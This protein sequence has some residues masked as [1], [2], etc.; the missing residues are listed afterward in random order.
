MQTIYKIM[1]H[2]FS[3]AREKL[4][5]TISVCL[6]CKWSTRRNLLLPRK[7]F[8]ANT[9]PFSHKHTIRSVQPFAPTGQLIFNPSHSIG[10]LAEGLG[11]TNA[12]R[13]KQQTINRRHAGGRRALSEKHSRKT[14]D[15]CI[16]LYSCTCVRDGWMQ[17][18]KPPAL[19]NNPHGIPRTLTLLS[20]KTSSSS[21]LSPPPKLD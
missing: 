15:G 8:S 2:H 5:R 11:N 7:P 19:S 12:V 4:A 14:A 6:R 20:H 13:W 10:H 18:I 16:I 1:R 17:K 21:F 9:K 3:N